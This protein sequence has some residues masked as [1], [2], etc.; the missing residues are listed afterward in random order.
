MEEMLAVER[1]GCGCQEEES[2]WMDEGLDEREEQE[3]E[4][5]RPFCPAEPGL[6]VVVAR[7]GEGQRV[8][9][10]QSRKWSQLERAILSVYAGHDVKHGVYAWQSYDTLLW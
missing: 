3:Q 4:R 10:Q 2:K 7:I 1:C 8:C 9:R 5:L 6:P